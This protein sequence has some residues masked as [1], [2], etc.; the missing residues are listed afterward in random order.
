MKRKYIYAIISTIVFLYL[1]INWSIGSNKLFFLKN[2]LPYEFNQTLKKYIFPLK[3]IKNKE[4]IIKN[5]DEI[6]QAQREELHK[7]IVD[8]DLSF[9]KNLKDF[10]FKIDSKKKIKNKEISIYKPIDKIFQMGISNLKPG[11]A[12]LDIYNEKLFLLSSVGILAYAEINSDELNFKQIK[13]NIDFFINDKQFKKSNGKFS[14]KDLKIFDNKIYASYTN[15]SEEDCWNTSIIFADLNFQE[16]KFKK[17][18]QP[19]SCVHSIKNDDGE[20][21]AHVSGGRIINFDNDNILLST[22]NFRSRKLAQNAS[23][24]FGKILKI[25]IING[26]YEV[27]SMGHRNPQGLYYDTENNFIL[28]TEHGPKGGDEINLIEI[29]ENNIPNYGWPVASYGEHYGGNTEENK[30]KYE[31]Y[32]LLKS[33]K[34]NGFIEPL[35]FFIPSIGISEIVGIENMKYLI[36]SMRDKSIYSFNLNQKNQIENLERIEVGERIRDMIH[37]QNKIFLFLEDS[38]SIGIINLN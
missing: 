26:K 38:G 22:G 10:N 11:S 30:S 27:I 25:N 9:K 19:N 14:I 31:K 17:L 24:V 16:L 20:F 36:A 12:Y 7:Y 1:I 35:K 5:K 37:D 32:P 4:L 15:E 21:N 34:K 8:F 3:V 6:I 13:N 18:F 2:L 33:H 23:N 28:S 29:N